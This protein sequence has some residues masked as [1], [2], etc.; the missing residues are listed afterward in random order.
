[1]QSEVNGRGTRGSDVFGDFCIMLLWKNDWMPTIIPIP[2]WTF[3]FIRK[4]QMTL[5]LK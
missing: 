5:A 2:S 3:L 4:F 1:M